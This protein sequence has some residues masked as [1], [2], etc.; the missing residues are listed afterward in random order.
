MISHWSPFHHP[1]SWRNHQ[2]NAAAT[3]L[4][5]AFEDGRTA[6]K[7]SQ[8]NMA[9]A[10]LDNG[11]GERHHGNLRWNSNLL[12]YVWWGPQS[13]SRSVGANNSNFT[14]VFVG[15][16]S[17][18]TGVYKPICNVWGAPPCMSDPCLKK[19]C[20]FISCY[21]YVVAHPSKWISAP[22]FD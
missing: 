16:I 21:I 12:L 10:R 8:S 19:W 4:D 14:M 20:V 17:I 1:F 2:T 6:S 15:D 13:S 9:S 22:H 11:E 3:L 5:V 18:V 7:A